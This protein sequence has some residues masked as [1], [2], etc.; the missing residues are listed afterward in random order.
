[1]NYFPELE[2]AADTLRRKANLNRDF[3]FVRLSE[4]LKRAAD[5]KVRSREGQP[6][7]V[8]GPQLRSRRPKSCC[9]PEG[10]RRGSRNFQLASQAG[11]I[12]Q[13]HLI[14]RIMSDASLTTDGARTS[15]RVAL[16]NYLRRRC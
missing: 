2:D 15:C 6:H 16:A 7:A 4:Y 5:V 11:L 1:M 3:I 14:D 13:G 8:G 10:L 12:T 9:F